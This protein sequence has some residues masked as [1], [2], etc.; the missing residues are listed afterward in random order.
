MHLRHVSFPLELRFVRHPCFLDVQG[1][2]MDE[3]DDGPG[4]AI[5][6]AEDKKYYPS[7]EE[8]RCFHSWS[9]TTRRFQCDHTASHAVHARH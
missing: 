5:M 4:Q 3:D 2:A 8:V 1:D 6:L 9:S 7:A